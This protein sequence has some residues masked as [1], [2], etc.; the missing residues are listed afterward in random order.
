MAGWTS[1]LAEVVGSWL[2]SGAS[3]VYNQVLDHFTAHGDVVERAL[4]ESHQQAWLTIKTALASPSMMQK[5]RG[6]LQSADQKRLT[7][8]VREFAE[9]HFRD[10]PEALRGRC[11]ESLCKA[12]DQGLLALPAHGGTLWPQVRDEM[13]RLP[14]ASSGSEVLPLGPEHAELVSLVSAPQAS[15]RPLLLELCRA[16]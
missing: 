10:R 2:D 5:V 15:G 16:F 4:E 6:A 3:G 1:F 14:G 8:T 13:A 7:N 12:Q 9:A 11:L